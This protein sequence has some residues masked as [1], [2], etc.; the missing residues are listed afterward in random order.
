M[1]SLEELYSL[2]MSLLVVALSEEIGYRDNDF[3]PAEKCLQIANNFIKSVHIEDIKN[4]ISNDFDVEETPLSWQ[5][6][7]D[8]V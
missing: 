3:V 7:S 4:E 2:L 8:D 1:Q 6:W 5:K